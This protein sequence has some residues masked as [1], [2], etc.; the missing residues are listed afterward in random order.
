MNPVLATPEWL[1]LSEIDCIF[2][3]KQI[4]GV[5]RCLDKVV[6][7]G[8]LVMC[9]AQKTGFPKPDFLVEVCRDD[10]PHPPRMLAACRIIPGFV[11]VVNNQ[12]DRKSPKDLVGLAVNLVKWLQNG[13]Y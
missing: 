11:C 12:G 13:A 3:Q 7:F 10:L 1:W 6:K 9:L 4:F 8:G 5:A 2:V